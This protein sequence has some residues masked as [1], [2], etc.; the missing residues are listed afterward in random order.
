MK[1]GR[2]DRTAGGNQRLS[3][4]GCDAPVGRVWLLQT[5]HD[6]RPVLEM[7]IKEGNYKGVHMEA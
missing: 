6:A 2:W 1:V 5:T 4:G 7:E 3:T